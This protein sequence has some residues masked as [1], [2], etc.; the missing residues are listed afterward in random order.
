MP[1]HLTAQQAAERLGL[2]QQAIYDMLR[3]GRLPNTTLGHGPVLIASGDVARVAYE[4]RVEALR[5]VG[6]ETEY[7]RRIRDLIWPPRVDVVR[8]DGRPDPDAVMA[9]VSAPRGHDALRLLP[10]PAAMLWGPSVLR[11]AA[12]RVDAGACRTCWAR[13]AA[14]VHQ[15]RGPDGSPACRLLLGDPC[16]Q[17]AAAWQ[18]QR[19]EARATLDRARHDMQAKSDQ[20]TLGRFE[21]D[22]R[23]ALADVRR[24]SAR[25]ADLDRQRKTAGLPVPGRTTRRSR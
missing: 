11:A 8:A 17:D 22:Y 1:S 21:A 12:M 2:S 18:R 5:R 7:A 24:A 4:R 19:R 9:S 10:A 23:A 20:R 13:C 25:F 3:A 14:A 15:T 6:D 16:S